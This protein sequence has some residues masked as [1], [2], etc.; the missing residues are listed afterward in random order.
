MHLAAV[1]IGLRVVRVDRDRAVEIRQRFGV[2]PGAAEHGTAHVVGLR[3]VWIALHDLAQGRDVAGEVACASGSAGGTP[4]EPI[5]RLRVAALHAASAT[6]PESSAA[7][8]AILTLI[9]NPAIGVE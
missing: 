2:A 3:V 6:A 1:G 5:P 8:A 7:R 9:R 4:L